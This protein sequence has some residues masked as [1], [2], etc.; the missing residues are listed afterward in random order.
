MRGPR[1]SFPGAVFHILNRFID[2]HPFFRNDADYQFFLDTY[3]SVA[4]AYGLLTYA[5]SLQPTHFHFVME[6]PSGELSKFLQ[7]F[8]TRVA[9]E[10][11][12]RH[13]RVGRLFQGRT[14]SLLV[15]SRAYFETAVGYVVLNALRAKR[16]PD[17][18]SYRWDSVR[19]MLKPT[20]SRISQDG[21]W[22][23]LW[24]TDID[25]RRRQFYRERTRQWLTE[26]KVDRITADYNRGHR[27]SFLGSA[28]FRNG[29]LREFERRR[30]KAPGNRRRSDKKTAAFS[31]AE[32]IR[33]AEQALAKP[34]AGDE[35]RDREKA[36]RDI[37]WYLG[38]ERLGLPWETIRNHSELPGIP[39]SRFSVSTTRLK[40]NPRKLAVADRA[41]SLFKG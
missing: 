30:K 19:E 34:K 5:Y 32:L 31:W 20:G 17:I 3:F 14:K 25:Q 11:N 33:V 2:R 4:D 21:L 10:L 24:E 16:T 13:Q 22:G 9:Q 39:L 41:W 1:I 28:D 40:R 27:G 36:I 37:C 35:W 26:L 12:R 8:L 18:F 23:H 6:T 15:D 7:R 29:I 38:H